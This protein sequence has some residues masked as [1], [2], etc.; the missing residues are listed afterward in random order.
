[1]AERDGSPPIPGQEYLQP[2]K[3]LIR[4]IQRHHPGFFRSLLEAQEA[5]RRASEVRSTAILTD[6]PTDE[7]LA[8][9]LCREYNLVN[10]SWPTRTLGTCTSPQGIEVPLRCGY[11]LSCVDAQTQTD[12]FPISAPAPGP[13]RSR[14]TYRSRSPSRNIPYRRDVNDTAPILR[15]NF[16]RSSPVPFPTSPLPSRT[17]K[18]IPQGI[19]FQESAGTARNLVIGTPSVRNRRPISATSVASPMSV[20]TIVQSATDPTN[21]LPT[22]YNLAYLIF[23][24][25]LP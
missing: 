23:P 5:Q 1:M 16:S 4:K 18:S 15:E 7:E 21:P 10:R 9:S 17:W 19:P 20:W 2:Y 11:S 12:P 22:V 8:R 25:F 24:A 13:S 6:V 3:S 14:D